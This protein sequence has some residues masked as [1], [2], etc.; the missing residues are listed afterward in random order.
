MLKRYLGL[1]EDEIKANSDL[2]H[3]ERAKPEAAPATGQDLRAVGITP[4]DLDADITAG[5]E[6]A[7]LGAP[8]LEVPGV[9][10]AQPGAQPGAAVA[11]APPAGAPPG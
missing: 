6:F 4:G 9:P 10:G 3:E 11:P 1:T 2:W 8:G 5:E 7:D